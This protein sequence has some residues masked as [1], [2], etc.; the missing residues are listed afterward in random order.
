VRDENLTIRQLAIKVEKGLR[1]VH[2]TIA[3][4]AEQIADELE[5]WFRA[6]AAD[7]FNILVPLHP[8]G[9]EDFMEQVVPILQ[10]RGLFRTEYDGTTLREHFGLAVPGRN[11]AGATA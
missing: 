2:W 8:K 11:P 5:R 3:G 6:G 1:N 7:G 10:R 9:T 4:S